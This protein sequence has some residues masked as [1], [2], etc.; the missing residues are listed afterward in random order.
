MV[1]LIKSTLLKPTIYYFILTLILLSSCDKKEIEIDSK[2]SVQL[3]Y[4]DG[5][6][7]LL[8]HGKPYFIKGASGN[9]NLKLLKEIGGN[10]VRT[11]TTE[12][13]KE[14]LD[15]AD[16]LG[17]TVMLGIW[18]DQ[19]SDEND[20]S[21][22][23]E[24]QKLLNYI[25]REVLRYKDHPALLMWGIGNEV[26]PINPNIS[27]WQFLDKACKM[28]KELD[29]NHPVTTSIAGYPRRNMFF[30]NLF[31]RNADFISFNTFGGINNLQEKMKNSIW[32]YY[33]AYL[34]SEWGY[35]GYWAVEKTRWKS[36][37]EPYTNSKAP[38]FKEIW[39]EYILKDSTKC[40]GGY[41]FYWG[42]KQ[43]LTNSWY[44]T[45]C[46]S[47]NKTAII[48]TLS[49]IWNNK[50]FE[51][52]TPHIINLTINK[53][54]NHKNI[55]IEKSSSNILNIEFKEYDNDSVIISSEIKHETS[56]RIDDYGIEKEPLAVKGLIEKIKD[57]KV[58][59][60]AP[61]KAG[62]YRIYVHLDDQNGNCDMGN[63]VFKVD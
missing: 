52:S 5:K 11:Y 45:F 37:M 4:K 63:L 54:H 48:D 3:I 14:I 23:I 44:S 55:V 40:I 47:G 13:A 22:E 9:G 29:S 15:K 2:K 39:T 26:H 8:R 19:Y 28:V 57:D 27:T 58:Y 17:L 61:P 18:I 24:N 7:T 62:I 42:Q 49:S 51:N 41:V 35:H 16:S 12:N 20:F 25:K 32:G 60:T 30:M 1:N 36:P 10:S 56:M 34:L 31:L 21:D 6:Y 46:K 59:F 53:E 50:K 38:R 43:E 33:N